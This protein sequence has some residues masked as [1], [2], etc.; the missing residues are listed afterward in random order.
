MVIRGT[1][2]FPA[3]LENAIRSVPQVTEYAVD[4]DRRG[5][6]DELRVRIERAED[7]G[8][9]PAAVA[10]SIRRATGLRAEVTACAVGV[11]PRYELKSRRVRDHRNTPI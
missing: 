1:V 6:L 3:A 10:E 9:A 11:L 7:G 5:T 8:G 2:V 4:V